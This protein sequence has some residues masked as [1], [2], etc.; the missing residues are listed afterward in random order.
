VDQCE[1]GAKRDFQQIGF[2]VN[3][4]LLFAL[5]DRGADAGRRQDTAKTITAGANPLDERPLRHELDVQFTRR[6]LPLGLRVE[7]DMAHDYLAQQPGCDKLSNSPSGRRRIVGNN[8]K[9][10]LILP[11]NLVDNSFRSADGHESSN[12]QTR[13]VGD[14]RD[15][16]FERYGLHTSPSANRC[17]R[18]QQT[19]AIAIRRYC[20]LT[21]HSF[22][23]IDSLFLAASCF[24]I[25]A[26]HQGRTKSPKSQYAEEV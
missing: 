17:R 20:G 7:T 10:P 18:F 12:H 9:V 22:P 1:V 13:A 11:N 15:R 4:D 21:A 3:F 8:R 23:S 14:H 2:P 16:L 26:P 24:L 6:H 5:L 19:R 25:Q